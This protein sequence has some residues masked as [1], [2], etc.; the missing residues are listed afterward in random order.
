[1]AAGRAGSR[2]GRG[3]RGGPRSHEGRVATP[4]LDVPGSLAADRPRRPTSGRGRA[5]SRRWSSSRP[6]SCWRSR[7]CS[8]WARHGDSRRRSGSRRMASSPT[9]RDAAAGST[10]RTPT[11]RTRDA[12]SARTGSSGLRSS[13]P[14][15]RS[16]C[17]GRGPPMTPSARP[18]HAA[19]RASISTSRTP[20]GPTSVVWPK[21]QPSRRIQPELPLGRP[22]RHTWSL[23]HGR[24]ATSSSFG[25]YRRTERARPRGS[26]AA[27]PI[28]HHRPGPRTDDGSPSR[29]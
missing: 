5:D 18:I 2:A 24:W 28:T 10:W 8:S 26:P 1:M 17:S 14:M 6:W 7:P 20:T 19:A 22:I 11:V 9:T 21:A 29:S 23:R 15:G 27:T 25:W 12:W 3:A 4:G 13:P 16:W